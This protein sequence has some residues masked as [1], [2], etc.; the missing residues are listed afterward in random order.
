[1]RKTTPALTLV[2]LF[3]ATSYIAVKL[4]ALASAQDFETIVIEEDGSIS[5]AS[6]PIIRNG[7]SYTLKRNVLGSITIAKSDIVFDG[8]GYTLQYSG[9]ESLPRLDSTEA[10][11]PSN[12]VG[13]S[14][15]TLD[16]VNNVTIRNVNI[17]G[18][19]KPPQSSSG[20]G[21]WLFDCNGSTVTNNS[22]SRIYYAICASGR[23]YG[24]LVAGNLIDEVYVGISFSSDYRISANN[25]TGNS[26]S[27]GYK[28]IEIQMSHIGDESGN[29]IIGNQVADNQIGMYFQWRGEYFFWNPYP[30]EMN[31]QIYYNNFVDNSKNVF[32]QNC[33]NI[34]DDNALGN[35]WSDYNGTDAN[36]DGIGDSPYTVDANNQDRYPLMKPWEPDTEP[37][38]ISMIS[39]ENRTYNESNVTLAFSASEPT[40]KISYSFDGQGNLIISGNITL[41][42]LPNGGHNITVYATDEAGNVGVSQIVYFEV[43]VPEPF[44]TTLV[45]ASVIIVAV[46]GIGLLVYFKRHKKEPG[47]KK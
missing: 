31:T 28:G 38:S 20:V 1:M 22:L 18:T 3:L 41:T 19:G 43:D 44:P 39:P 40:S 35:Y 23:C 47:N 36:S 16:I 24:N 34:W 27:G 46:F 14:E 42:G 37:P 6:A 13:W 17:I 15:L 5:P 30:F 12:H 11:Q 21:I 8:A 32:T 25:I 7:S 29:V 33:V 9:D 45:V 2:L 26:I 10:L 4:V